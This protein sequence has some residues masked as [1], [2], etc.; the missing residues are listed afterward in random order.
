MADI[1]V[2]LQA[3]LDAVYGE[4]V[5]GSIHDAIE[6]INDAME[7]SISAGTAISSASSSSAGFYDNSLYINTNTYDL[8]KCIGTNSWSKLGNL[9]GIG[10]S[11]IAKTGTAA[12]V[13]TYTITFDDGETETFTVTNGIDGTNGS[14]WY[15][16]TALTGT[17]TSITGFPGELNDFY[18]NSSTGYVYV[19]TKSGAAMVPDAAEWDYVMTLT[20]GGG[21]GSIIVIDN[22]TSSSS[23]DALS[24][25]QGRVLKGLVDQKVDVGSLAQVATSGSFND[26]GDKPVVSQAYAP[27]SS[28]A[29]SGIAVAEGIENRVHKVTLTTAADIAAGGT[30]VVPAPTSTGGGGLTYN[31]DYYIHS[32]SVV[33]PVADQISN[34]PLKIS[35]TVVTAGYDEQMRECG[36]VTITLAEALPAGSEIG[37]VV[38]NE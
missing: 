35:S 37:V 19:C 27:T 14:I 16:G 9:R 22:L 15:K 36:Y 33:I 6:I 18:L 38:I 30:V 12:N 32:D 23:T 5:R 1:S 21:G 25:N 11:S 7:V 24:A 2:Y 29:Q 31:F 4:Q 34:R 10:I 8:W 3:I 26:L 13:D 17:G 20:G 28:N